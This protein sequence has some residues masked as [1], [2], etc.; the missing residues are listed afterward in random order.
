MYLAVA[1]C[2]ST[3][4]EKATARATQQGDKPLV[5]MATA[6]WCGPCRYFKKYVLHSPEVQQALRDVDFVMFDADRS[7]GSLRALGVRAFPTFVV[8]NPDQKPVAAL[9]GAVRSSKFVDFLQWGTPNWFTEASMAQHLASRP[10]TRVRTYGARFYALQG[11]LTRARE[12][13]HAA[14]NGLSR[15]EAWRRPALAW[16]SLLVGHVGAPIDAVAKRAVDFIGEYPSSPEIRAAAEVAL[17][18][19]GLP[20][21]SERALAER[22]VSLLANDA[23]ALNEVAYT[24]LA[25][26]D[27]EI[28]LQAAQRQVSLTPENAN[29]FDTLGETLNVLGCRDQAVQAA[30]RALSLETSSD[31]RDHYKENRRRFRKGK[32]SPS[33]AKHVERVTANLARYRIAARPR[34]HAPAPR[35]RPCPALAW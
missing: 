30:N 34:H 15:D 4:L 7:A 1:A 28:A 31:S 29:A 2:G 27:P 11:N 5:V 3:D 21:T 10:S 32:P 16:E 18:S 14:M 25:A 35:R 12:L 26:G 33:L 8:V 13:Y 24:L 20:E 22:V 17:L 9:T 19:G 23:I 6:T